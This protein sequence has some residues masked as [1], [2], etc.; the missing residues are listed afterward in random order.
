MATSGPYSRPPPPSRSAINQHTTKPTKSPR[1][2]P[3]H[4]LGGPRRILRRIRSI[5]EHDN[6][7][8]SRLRQSADAHVSAGTNGA[9]SPTLYLHNI[10]ENEDSLSSDLLRSISSV[11]DRDSSNGNETGGDAPDAFWAAQRRGDHHAY[12][13]LASTDSLP[14]SI[15]ASVTTASDVTEIQSIYSLNPL[16]GDVSVRVADPSLPPEWFHEVI[17]EEQ[18]EM[19][20]GAF[21]V[22]QVPNCYLYHGT[23]GYNERSPVCSRQ[24]VPNLLPSHTVAASSSPSYLIDNGLQGLAEDA[25]RLFEFLGAAQ[26]VPESGSSQDVIP[27][28]ASTTQGVPMVCVAC[29]QAVQEDSIVRVRDGRIVHLECCLDSYPPSYSS[30][31]P[32]SDR[33]ISFSEPSPMC[34]TPCTPAS[35]DTGWAR[36]SSWSIPSLLIPDARNATRPPWLLSTHTSPLTSYLPRTRRVEGPNIRDPY[37]T[38]PFACLAPSDISLPI[39]LWE[40]IIDSLLD[41]P[42][43]LLACAFVCKAWYARCRMHLSLGVLQLGHR[44]DVVRLSRYVRA[45]RAFA[46]RE[47]V[48]VQGD[49]GRSLSHLTAFSAQ[50]AG[51]MQRLESLYIE[52]GVWRTGMTD[53]GFFTRVASFTSVVRLTLNDVTFPSTS[54][55]AQFVCALEQ[56]VELYCINSKTMKK[57]TG[58]QLFLPLRRSS[59][60]AHFTLVGSQVYDIIGFFIASDLAA[61][62]TD[63]TLHVGYV[64]YRHF[65]HLDAVAY[66]ELLCA[67]RSLRAL[68]LQSRDVA[69]PNTVSPDNVLVHYLN[70]STRHNLEALHLSIEPHLYGDYRCGWMVTFLS[71]FCSGSTVRELDI[72]FDIQGE[73]NATAHNLLLARLSDET[74]MSLLDRVLAT[75]R[76]AGL[77]NVEVVLRVG[78]LESRLVKSR[79]ALWVER[80]EGQLRN[81]RLRGILT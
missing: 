38:A 33:Q 16:D 23:H 79:E 9:G 29:Q 35:L 19:A 39:E 50:L 68:H 78:H 18:E 7:P 52:H 20:E 11:F 48:T 76:Y 51:R 17:P 81:V 31:C 37:S 41:E 25:S 3:R 4:A 66:R 45:H 74:D 77:E 32:T 73:T 65:M 70:A 43:A 13:A 71:H 6:D 49:A 63:L 44:R 75:R 61:K 64:G 26:Q 42:E 57:R 56:L 1:G 46:R 36:S 62:L 60:L 21:A 2:Q 24:Q 40:E 22:I 47:F 69:L 30:T 14:L 15:D 34:S 80:V 27:S 12:A 28:Q 72:T 8:K 59:R 55:F 5:I 53:V 54:I 58:Q 10:G 67:C